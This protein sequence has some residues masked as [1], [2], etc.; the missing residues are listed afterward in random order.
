LAIMTKDFYD[1]VAK[2]FGGYG[3]G[4]SLEYTK[5]FTNGDPEVT[6]KDKILELASKDKIALDIGCA[7]GWFTTKVSPQFKK[8]YGIDT[9]KVNL[10]IANGHKNKEGIKNVEYS[11][12]DA[13]NTNF[14][15]S[16]FDLA[17]CRRGP[18]YFAEYYRILKPGGH[19]LEIKIGERDAMGIKKVFGRGQD[20]GEWDNS[21]MDKDIGE[22][23]KLG[24]ETIFS[25]NYNYSEY[26]PTYEALD[27][28]LQGVPIFENYDTKK[29]KAK[30]DEYI[31]QN[32]SQKGIA[33]PRH[34]A[35]LVAKKI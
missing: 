23:K 1:R 5:E 35:V 8:V 19:Y 18:T 32:S 15:D 3:Q 7:D 6:F 28:F 34:R 30:L 22:L 13:A 24:F 17:Y 4:R 14:N 26:Y 2:K 27:L 10:E 33:L 25:E 20:F 11:F 16:F 29:D 31:S 12:Q 21:R 9:S